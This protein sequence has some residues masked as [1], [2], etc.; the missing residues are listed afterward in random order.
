MIEYWKRNI[1]NSWNVFSR[2]YILLLT[3]S[4]LSLLMLFYISISIND[5]SMPLPKIVLIAALSLMSLGIHIGSISIT[6]KAI[7]GK[8]FTFKD[9]FQQ[10]D[11][12]HLILIPNIGLFAILF[13]LITSFS[14]STYLL[15][16]I[17]GG[18]Y[19]AFLYFYDYLIIIE[20]LSMKEAIM[21]NYYLV[22]NN[23]AL[24]LQFVVVSFLIGFCLSIFQVVGSMLAMCFVRI[25]GINLYLA[26]SKS[27]KKN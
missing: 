4:I 17:A 24:V 14:V 19:F 11:K 23:L 25:V 2:N 6:Y 21:K 3:P 12:L 5:T 10:F 26:I 27:I 16:L 15:M 20:K 9:I 13:I 1:L 8:K 18:V 22:S 7:I